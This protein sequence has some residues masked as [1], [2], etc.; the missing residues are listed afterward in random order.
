MIL[1]N[2]HLVHTGA[3]CLGG[4]SIDSISLS[5]LDPLCWLEFNGRNSF[6]C[7]WNYCTFLRKLI[8]QL[9]YWCNLFLGLLW[10][11]KARVENVLVFVVLGQPIV[12]LK[13]LHFH[14]IPWNEGGLISFLTKQ[15]PVNIGK[16]GVL[17]DFSNW[18][19]PLARVFCKQSFNQVAQ[20][21]FGWSISWDS[22][23]SVIW[24]AICKTSISKV[25]TASKVD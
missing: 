10:R 8:K 16:P 18:L 12:L 14:E 25:R 3:T 19:G 20:K 2:C 6:E 15:T 22:N 9:L 7:R 21:H 13:E 23:E 24:L 5:V 17:L 11:E 1:R 4:F